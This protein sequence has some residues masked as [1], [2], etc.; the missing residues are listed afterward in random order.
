MI[1]PLDFFMANPYNNVHSNY[2][3]KSDDKDMGVSLRLAER[4]GL[5]ESSQ[6]EW[7]AYPL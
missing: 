5:V 1:W 6:H 2:R 4:E 3:S 7:N